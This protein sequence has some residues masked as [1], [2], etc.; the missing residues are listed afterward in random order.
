MASAVQVENHKTSASSE[1]LYCKVKT[2]INHVR[3]H[4]K[5]NHRNH[6]GIVPA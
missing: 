6:S 3:A 4:R 1:K 2:F 5:D